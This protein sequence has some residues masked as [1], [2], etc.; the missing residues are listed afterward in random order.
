M[1]AAASFLSTSYTLPALRG[2]PLPAVPQ[3][4]AA[5]SEGLVLRRVAAELGHFPEQMALGEMLGG[6]DL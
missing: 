5:R 2:A 6:L 1:L 4:G 3:L